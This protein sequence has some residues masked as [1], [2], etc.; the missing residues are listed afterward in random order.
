MNETLTRFLSGL[1]YVT[2]LIVATAYSAQSFYVLFGIFLI[3]TLFEFCRILKV[4]FYL[5]IVI[6]CVSYF[7]AAKYYTFKSFDLFILGFTLITSFSLVRLLF[8]TTKNELSSV[9]KYAYVLGYVIFPFIIIAKIPFSGIDFRPK[10]IISIFILIW[11]NDTFAYI[12]GKSVGKRKLFEKISPK[13]TIE[14]FLGGLFFSVVAGILISKFYF[15][16]SEQHS[17]KSLFIWSVT[18]VIIS[19]FS[20]LGDLIES[21]FKRIAG[22]K[23]SGTIMPGHGGILD[24][25]DSIIFV[26]PFV[27]LFY[28][29]LYYVS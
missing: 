11:T 25:L 1:V 18:A 24:R 13:K 16:P 8:N 9:A 26:A 3:I 22:V 17:M 10:I 4:N 15:N 14:G 7:L 21:K 19:I 28:Q 23:D 20:T 29:I 2:L 5:P 27:F 6:A 12:V